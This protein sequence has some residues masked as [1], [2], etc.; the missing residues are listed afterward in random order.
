MLAVP[1]LC[2][3]CPDCDFNLCLCSETGNLFI[4][5]DYADGGEF[6]WKGDS[7]GE[8]FEI[9]IGIGIIYIDLAVSANKLMLTYAYDM[10]HCIIASTKS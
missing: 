9:I 7:S 8:T 4:V 3:E 10:A 6:S 2:I 5:M 1:L